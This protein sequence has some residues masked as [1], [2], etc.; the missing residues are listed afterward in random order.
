MQEKEGRGM[1]GEGNM[2]NGGGGMI[3]VVVHTAH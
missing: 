1:W 2:G 3:K